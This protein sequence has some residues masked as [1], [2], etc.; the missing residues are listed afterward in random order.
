MMTTER[1][2]LTRTE[3]S[4]MPVL[5]LRVNSEMRSLIDISSSAKR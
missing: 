5:G 2:M 1:K 3:I 4:G